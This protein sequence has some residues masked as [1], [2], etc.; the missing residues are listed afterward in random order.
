MALRNVLAGDRIRLASGERFNV[1]VGG[2]QLQ[3][4]S[5]LASATGLKTLK[6]KAQGW[7]RLSR[8]KHDKPLRESKGAEDPFRNATNSKFTNSNHL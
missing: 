6:W 7:G 4:L 1:L 3:Q 2:G 8:I 5:N